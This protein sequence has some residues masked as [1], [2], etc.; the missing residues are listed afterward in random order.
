MKSVDRGEEQWEIPIAGDT[1]SLEMHVSFRGM[2]SPMG[3]NL[4]KKQSY[5]CLKPWVPV[6]SLS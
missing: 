6:S 5:F 2:H 3:Q 4:I 1:K